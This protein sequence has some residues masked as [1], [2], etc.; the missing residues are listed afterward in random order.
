MLVAAVSLSGCRS[1][2]VL[3]VPEPCPA[4]TAEQIVSLATMIHVGLYP[5][6]EAIVSDYEAHCCG[7]DALAGRPLEEHCE[8]D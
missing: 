4:P 3:V 6:V 1:G 2:V 5:G 7:D 8:D